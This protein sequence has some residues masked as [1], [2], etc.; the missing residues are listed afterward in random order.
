MTV[1]GRPMLLPGYPCLEI[2]LSPIGSGDGQTG[3]ESGDGRAPEKGARRPQKHEMDGCFETGRDIYRRARDAF[4]HRP[5]ES[6]E[7]QMIEVARCSHLNHSDDPKRRL[8]D[9]SWSDRRNGA[10]RRCRERSETHS[11]A[12]MWDRGANIVFHTGRVRLAVTPAPAPWWKPGGRA[13]PDGRSHLGM[14][15]L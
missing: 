6:G 11:C 10:T 9:G 13:R 7:R 14:P 3:W 2:C 1:R 5:N 15:D 8:R 4:A 12:S